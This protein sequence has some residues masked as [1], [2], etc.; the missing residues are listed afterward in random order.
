MSFKEKKGE[1]GKREK[2]KKG[3]CLKKSE[4]V[5]ALLDGN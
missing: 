3:P 4:S 1:E 2:K 5:D